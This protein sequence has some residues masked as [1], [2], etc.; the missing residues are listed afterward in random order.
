MQEWLMIA[1][2]LLALAQLS[3]Q[4]EYLNNGLD[5][6]RLFPDD[7]KLRKPGYCDRSIVCQNS[8]ST[9]GEICSGTKPFFSLSK[10]ACNTPDSSDAYCKNPCTS[11]TSGYV[12]DTMNCANW[13]YCD[14]ANLLG[15]GVCGN[16]MWFDQ[17]RKICAYPSDVP[18]E[19]KFELCQVMPTGVAAMDPLYCNKYFTCKGGKATTFTCESGLYYDVAQKKCI[20]KSLVKCE[21]HPVPE[22]VCG[23]KKLAKRGK[24][25]ADGATC[26]GYY[27]CRDLGSGV[28]DTAPVWHQC[29]LETFFNENLELCQDRGA[30]K[31]NEDRCDGRE[32]GYEL[33]EELGCQHYLECKDGATIDIHKCPDDT[34][35]D[36]PT[37]SC[38]P[39]KKNYGICNADPDPYDPNNWHF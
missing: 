10:G 25:V 6:C 3:W 27:Y 29:P 33:A 31:C 21:K 7:T 5:V 8:M 23:T 15:S 13:Y 4:T 16:G 38:T 12:G 32:S 39:E 22:D 17:T 30:R 28:P 26:R 35:F 2:L 9:E 1:L 37:K 36:I 19:A 24:F 18:C 20:K 11:K 14:K 34:Y